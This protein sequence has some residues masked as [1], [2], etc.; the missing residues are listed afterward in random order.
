MRIKR[1]PNKHAGS[2]DDHALTPLAPHQYGPADAQRRSSPDDLPPRRKGT[3]D[4]HH[5]RPVVERA[6]RRRLPRHPA[7]DPPQL[8][9]P[10]HQTPRPPRRPLPTLRRA[11]HPHLVQRPKRNRPV[12][13]CGAP[14]AH[15]GR[16][17]RLDH[18]YSATGRHL[19]RS[20][21]HPRHRRRTSSRRATRPHARRRRTCSEI[22]P[23]RPHPA[24]P[25]PPQ[26]RHPDPRHRRA[27]IR[28]DSEAR[29]SRRQEPE[30]RPALPPL[31]RPTH[32][33]RHRRA[34]AR[35]SHSPSPRRVRHRRPRPQRH[36][37]SQNLPQRALR[38]ARARR[39]PG[40]H[41]DQPRPRHRPTPGSTAQG[42][43]TQP[44]PRRVATVDRP[45]RGRSR[46]RAA[47][48]ARLTRWLLATDVRIGEPIA[49][50]WSSIDLDQA[51][52]AIDYKMLR[53]KGEGLQ[54]I[55]R[56][57]GEAASLA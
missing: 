12:G 56:A 43:G 22:G 10:R 51:T 39:S 30:H 48:P 17:V 24:R 49:V 28:R 25:Q 50:D 15:T 33:P 8:A 11:R 44:H 36:G 20:H 38:H 34:S 13:A 14:P 31:H 42:E 54:R 57:G 2:S 37:R 5:Q 27:M 40:R 26:H 55:R 47:R 41:P 19:V 16:I 9:H 35:R 32:S 3:S 4:E 45:A 23:H 7:Q 52:V 18:P 46:R 1:P 53:F 29:R 6:R 21:L